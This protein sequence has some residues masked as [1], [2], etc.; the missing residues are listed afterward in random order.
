M[1]QSEIFYAEMSVGEKKEHLVNP[2]PSNN[3]PA[4]AAAAA[5]TTT[6]TLPTNMDMNYV[7]LLRENFELRERNNQLIKL[8][9]TLMIEISQLKLEI[10]MLELKKAL[11]Q[12]D[13]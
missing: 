8:N 6:T 11:A 13:R 1:F 10:D 3:I 7:N 5:S 9:N 2:A 12:E 4:F